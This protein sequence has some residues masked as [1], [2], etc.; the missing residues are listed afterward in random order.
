MARGK[1]RS[2]LATQ[3]A[4][5]YHRNGY[6]RR[7]NALRL[8]REGPQYKKGDEVRLVAA[9][10]AELATIRRLLRWAGFTPGRPFRKGKQLRQ[11]IY[12]RQHVARFLALLGADD[13]R[14]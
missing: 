13:H 10:R 14:G 1:R 2:V 7:Q 5:F 6:V 8:A 11:P 4:Y 3:L 9:S 12:G